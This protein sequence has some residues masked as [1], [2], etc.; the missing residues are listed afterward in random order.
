[1]K[2]KVL[3]GVLVLL[4]GC[5]RTVPEQKTTYTWLGEHRSICFPD[6]ITTLPMHAEH[7]FLLGRIEFTYCEGKHT[8]TSWTDGHDVPVGGEAFWLELDSMGI[9]YELNKQ[10]LGVGVVHSNNDS[11]NELIAMALAA[12]SRPGS[13]G[14]RYPEIPQPKI[15]T[16]DFTK[17]EIYDTTETHPK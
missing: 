14:L 2:S 5:G 16:V 11:I 15:E 9:I 10:G 7:D 6:S 12:A 13:D 1:M 8:L 17:P 4:A 3:I